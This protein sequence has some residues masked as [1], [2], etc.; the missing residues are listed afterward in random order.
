MAR[1][2]EFYRLFS[3]DEKVQWIKSKGEVIIFDDY[4]FY[5]L[6]SEDQKGEQIYYLIEDYSGCSFGSGKNKK[7]AMLNLE[8][9]LNNYTKEQIEELTKKTIELY[10]ENPAH[11][12]TYNY[13]KN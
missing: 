7:E 8:E 5:G 1:Y 3:V 2:R 13:V 9:R 12:V 11:K 6:K 4:T 10:G